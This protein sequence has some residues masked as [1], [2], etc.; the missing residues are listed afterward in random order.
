[1]T[2][3]EDAVLPDFENPPVVETVL[4]AQFEKLEAMRSV[5]FGLF[6][7]RVREQFPDTQDQPPL[8]P[9]FEQTGPQLAGVPRI[10][11]LPQGVPLSQRL[12]LINRPGTEMIQIQND[13]FI[14]NWRKAGEGDKYP[15]YEP[16]IKP[17]FKRDFAMFER[18]LEDEGIGRPRINQCEVTYVNHI[19]S[20]EGWNK[21]SEVDKIFT[22][23]MQSPGRHPAVEDFAVRSRYPILDQNSDLIGRLHLDVFPALRS[24]DGAP[25]YVMNLT[26]R[27]KYSEGID[28]FDIGRRWIVKCFKNLTTKN[29]HEV[30]KGK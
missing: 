8:D 7:E 1:V 20:G 2:E 13:R 5:H 3:P 30:W 11:F 21:W 22:F 12:W 14:K 19:V 25:M 17:A 24:S 16:V 23:W 29:M 15:H 26:A 27:G 18:F 9:V 6:W 28:F 4:S 10:Q